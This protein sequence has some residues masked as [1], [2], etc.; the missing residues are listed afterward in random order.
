MPRFDEMSPEEL[1][2]ITS[3]GGKASAK[4]KK[5]Q[6]MT[7]EEVV[8]SNITNQDLKELYKGMLNSGKKGNVKAVETLLRY[9]DKKEPTTSLDDFIDAE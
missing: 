1:A 5:E 8:R 4:A 9:L 3:K 6:D 2:K 7:F